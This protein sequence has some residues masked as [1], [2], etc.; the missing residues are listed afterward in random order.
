[1][2][3]SH[4]YVLFEEVDAVEMVNECGPQIPLL[5]DVDSSCYLPG[6]TALTWA[7]MSAIAAR[8]GP[9]DDPLPDDFSFQ[10][11]PDDLDR[12]EWY[13]EDAGACANPWQRACPRSSMA[14]FPMR[15]MA[16]P[17]QAHA[18]MPNAFEAWFYLWHRPRRRTNRVLAEWVTEGQTEWDMWSAIR[19]YADYTDHDYCVAKG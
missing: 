18:G 12:L 2:T 4:Q 5:R 13:V 9:P 6:N 11:P 7:L 3:M 15:R 17:H 8:V 16:T 1:M 19:R 14:P 10:L